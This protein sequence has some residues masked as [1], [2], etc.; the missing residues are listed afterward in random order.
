MKHTSNAKKVD[1][2]WGY[3]LWLANNKERDYCGKILHIDKGHKSSMHFH[4]N[5]HETFYVLKGKLSVTLLDTEMGVIGS[6][7]T[8]EEG[9]T[10]EIRPFEPHQLEALEEL[11]L[12]EISTFHEDSDSRR[13]WR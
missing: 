5:K 8:L 6:V 2:S 13:V 11:D 9:E 12:I 4:V 7:E 3:E 10:M 1:K